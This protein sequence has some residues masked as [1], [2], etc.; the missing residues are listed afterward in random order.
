MALYRET[1]LSNYEKP[2]RELWPVVTPAVVNI[3]RFYFVYKSLCNLKV[4]LFCMFSKLWFCFLENNKLVVT[5]VAVIFSVCSAAVTCS[6]S[7][8]GVQSNEF[9]PYWLRLPWWIST[10][11]LIM[12]M[13]FRTLHKQK[14]ISWAYSETRRQIMLNYWPNAKK[15]TPTEMQWQW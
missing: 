7:P 2:R 3:D 11:V 8:R 15:S 12:V 5:F 13:I 14:L 9:L 6:Y 1:C 10:P 4:Y